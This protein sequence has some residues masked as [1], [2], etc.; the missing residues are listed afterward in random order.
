VRGK[1]FHENGIP[2]APVALIACY[3]AHENS[4][5]S[6][7]ERGAGSKQGTEGGEMFHLLYPFLVYT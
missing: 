5:L 2:V 3:S 1:Y 7:N 6:C 4:D